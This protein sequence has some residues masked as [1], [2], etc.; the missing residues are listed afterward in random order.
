MTLQGLVGTKIPEASPKSSL[1][2]NLKV[3]S[4]NI[5]RVNKNNAIKTPIKPN[6][7]L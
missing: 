3:E 2:N 5:F 7:N 6:F 4:Y 1:Q